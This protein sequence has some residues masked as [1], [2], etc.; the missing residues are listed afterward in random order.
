M[1][2]SKPPLDVNG[3]KP[4]PFPDADD[5]AQPKPPIVLPSRFMA[6]SNISQENVFV[7]VWG[8]QK[9]FFL[10]FCFLVEN[11]NFTFNIVIVLPHLL[12]YMWAVWPK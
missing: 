6:G 1:L 3:T 12:L 11:P 5:K 8:T 7:V 2:F 9:S 4:H 10:C